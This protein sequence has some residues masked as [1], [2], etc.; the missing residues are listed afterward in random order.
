MKK[1]LL[2]GVVGLCLPLLGGYLFLISGGMPVATKGPPLPMEKFVAR[3]ALHAAMKN[4]EDKPS[5]VPADE[6]NLLAGA[7]T[8]MNHCS[9]CHGLP[10]RQPSFIA[11][12]LFPKP[13]QLFEP[14]H[15]VTDDPVGESFWKVKNGIRLTGMPGFV[16]N[17][18]ET[19]MWQVSQLVTNADKLPP[20]VQQ[21]L[22]QQALVPKTQ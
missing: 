8:Y 13:P 9:V 20:T 15:G 6:L 17:L 19:E 14:D 1:F 11:K 4:E 16:D 22:D 18:S 2:G 5:P 10:S 21:S 3:T 7:K 12:G